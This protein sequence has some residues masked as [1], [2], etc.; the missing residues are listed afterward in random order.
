MD[1]KIF[2]TI[3]FSNGEKIEN[4]TLNGNNYVSKTEI[5]EDMFNNL[6]NITIIGSDNSKQIIQYGKLL[7]IAH[8]QD[9]WYF[10]ITE[11]SPD[12][13]FKEKILANID[14]IAMETGIDLED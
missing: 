11:M 14:Y 2:Y 9:G 5:T 6:L 7:Q 13:I 12:E 4:L 3:E 8:Y 1:E 10:I